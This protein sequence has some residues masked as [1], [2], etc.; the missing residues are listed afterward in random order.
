MMTSSFFSFGP[1]RWHALLARMFFVFVLAIGGV[2]SA[3]ACTAGACVTAGPRLA[4]VDSAKGAL[5]NAL[6]GN[7]TGSTLNLSVADWNALATG[8]VSLAST[9]SLLQSTMGVASPATALN[10]NATLAQV[11]GAAATAASNESNTAVAL[12]LNNLKVPLSAVGGAIRLGDLIQSDG[13]LGT[14]R[15][16]ALELAKGVIQLYNL[17]NV[18]TTPSPITLS[19]TNL[20]IAGL[21]SSVT[22][23]AQVVEA[24]VFV[25]GPVGSTLHTATLR[26]KLGIDLLTLTL[27]NTLLKAVPLVGTA[28]ATIGH[29]DLYLE[30][31]RADGI[32]SSINAITN[33]F[34]V[35]ATPGVADLYLGIMSDAVFF[36][37]GHA[38]NAATDL[39]WS[40]IGALTINGTGV[41]IQAK[42][43]AHG[44]AG[45]PTTLNFSG[46]YPQG[47]TASVGASFASNLLASLAANL[48]IN[49]TAG[50]LA[51]EAP[52]A[53]VLKPL[54]QLALPGILQ[55]L[56]DGLI[57][58]LL[59]LLG[60]GLGEVD[61]NAGGTYLSCSISGTV[62]EDSNHSARLESGE[63]G[64][65]ATLYAKLVTAAQ[66]AG[67]ALAVA[68]VDPT[69]GAYTF[70]GVTAAAY[71]VII[72]TS[73]TASQVTPAPPA[74]WI[75]TEVPTLS[76][77]ATITT[78]DL[79]AK[80]FGLYHGSK[81]AG[82][83]FNDNGVG[84]GT[85]NNG[86]RDG[87]EGVFVG[88]AVKLTDAAGATVY[89]STTSGDSGA[90][91]LWVPFAAGNVALKVTHAAGAD[92]IAVSGH[93]GSTAG[94]YTQVSGTVAFT[95]ASGSLYTGVNFGDVAANR[96][97]PDG[98]QQVL[99]GSVAFFTHSFTAGSGG[100]VAITAGGP[101][102]VGWGVTLYVDANCNGKLD[103]A[104]AL[105]AASVAVVADQ[106]VCL[107]AKVASPASAPYN[108]QYPVALTAH[109]VYANNS[110]ASDHVRND[111]V[112][113]GSATDSGLRLVKVV[114]KASA[115][116]GDVLVYTVTYLNQSDAALTT[117][118]ILDA[119]PAYTV[120]AS[121]AC[122]VMPSVAITCAVTTAPAVGNAG[123]V[124]WTF[125]GPLAAGGTGSV[126]LSV[127]L[128]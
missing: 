48:Q 70:T 18:A 45:S 3:Q 4:S 91:A 127:V 14:T 53:L 111:L 67:P 33:A 39:G 62:Y 87:T 46:T 84:A 22:L 64:T 72:N 114:D 75:A 128:Q 102:T 56:V 37:R 10:T 51:L 50:L 89:D 80:R 121:A 65:G 96:F 63:T 100:T 107:I 124:V 15:I 58:P 25:C 54:I 20:G 12:A 78:A 99:P 26:V 118:K 97:E 94:A 117:L 68:T 13:V 8:S 82:I 73:A 52:V 113:V 11:I 101:A 115:V 7:L 34:S 92:R 55:P 9:V 16:D 119:T 27:D 49:L 60:V 59:G 95:H 66:P 44:G 41:S 76:L 1:S 109:Y 43:S 126:T 77:A 79:S 88:S 125:T 35:Q 40:T 6:L 120:F 90:Y 93:I 71:L 61:V 23:S 106:K 122:G 28:V 57:D 110:L 108:A 19:G 69:S 36:N 81:L 123:A 38:L 32:I 21:A 5:L 104:E 86:V 2:T 116:T 83:V 103:A 24:P 30:V 42:A 74:G 29:L 85:A 112:T 98:Q 31:A 47:Q 105:I 17:K